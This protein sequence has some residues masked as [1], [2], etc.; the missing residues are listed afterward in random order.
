MESK[1][2]T[3]LKNF[4]IREWIFLSYFCV[5]FAHMS[6][7]YLKFI[8]FML[9]IF[10]SVIIFLNNKRHSILSI[11]NLKIFFIWYCLFSIYI[12]ISQSWQVVERPQA[13]VI[14][15]IIRIIPI[16]LCISYYINSEQKLYKMINIFIISICYT[17]ILALLT[18]PIQTY[19]TEGFRGITSM[20]RNS[21][22]HICAIVSVIS[23][24]MFRITNNKVYNLYNI[25][26]IF[27]IICTGSRGALLSLVFMFLLIF[28]LE[29]NISKKVKWS[30][31]IILLGILVLVLY[32]KIPYLQDVFGE[33]LLA[34]FSDK[35]EDNGSARDRA[36]YITVG[37]D[38]LKQSP[39]LGW[40]IDNFAYYLRQSGYAYEVYSHN[41]YIE[42]LSSF[43]IIGFILYYWVYIYIMKSVLVLRNNYLIKCITVI[44]LRFF[45]FEY[46][47]ISFYQY[48][49]I[50]ILTILICGINL[51]I[52][53]SKKSNY[54]RGLIK[55]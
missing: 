16:G 32:N 53:N 22:G 31:L 37:L 51:Y 24:Y 6:I 34:I 44:I 35:Y 27:T 41:N 9:V 3:K 29:K 12:F 42:V 39:L 17:A 28:L 2:L 50:I 14:P 4:G 11:K 21:L 45:V 10:S 18:S 19:G 7:P 46:A 20:H 38:M 40:G 47:T 1:E 52:Q 55:G 54:N 23:F 43:G 30:F 5:I 49:Y 36:Y 48:A 8:I 26:C 25:V 33:R 15:T 13:D